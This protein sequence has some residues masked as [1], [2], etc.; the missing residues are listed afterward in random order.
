M[1]SY[2]SLYKIYKNKYIKLKYGGTRNM[3][4]K[5]YI[6]LNKEEI[7]SML[8][9]VGLDNTVDNIVSKIKDENHRFPYKYRFM[10]AEDTLNNFK[11]LSAYKVTKVE[12]VKYVIRNTY[13]DSVDF[14]GSPLVF[15]FNRPDD[16]ETFETLS[17]YFQE[18]CRMKCIKYSMEQSVYDFWYSNTDKVVRGA[19]EKFK[20]IDAYTLREALYYMTDECTSFKPTLAISVYKLF[21][22]KK[23]LDPS[24]GWGDRLIGAMAHNAEYYC[25][26]DPNS[27]VHPNYHKMVKFFGADPD[28]FNFVHA[29][30]E[31][32]DIPDIG[33]DT[34]FTSPPFFTL[35]KYTDEGEQSIK[36]YT[37]IESWIDN[38]LLV[39][40]KKSL[41]LLVK[42]GYIIIHIRD[43]KPPMKFVR[44]MIDFMKTQNTSYLGVIGLA[45]STK[46]DRPLNPPALWI[47]QKN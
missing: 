40:L 8:K 14:K 1:S 4:D 9:S 21:N 29:P 5:N 43:M 17:D 3:I 46:L 32:A 23:I 31:T 27:C 11:K 16:Y 33:Y 25:G 24:S 38:F 44:P 2:K 34:V 18:K 26:V 42:G 15:V 19:I 47:W 37:S 35:E 12:G 36:K 10:S 41:G 13:V 6:S 30:F 20:H 7:E 22:S 39:V 28:K 45:K